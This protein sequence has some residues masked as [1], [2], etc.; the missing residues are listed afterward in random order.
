MSDSGGVWHTIL[1]R[2]CD[3]EMKYDNEND[4]VRVE[5]VGHKKADVDYRLSEATQ[6][7]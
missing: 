4:D 2:E 1:C 7:V 3:V 6:E 5:Y